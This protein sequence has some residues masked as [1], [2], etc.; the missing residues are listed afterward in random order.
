MAGFEDLV[1]GFEDRG[2]KPQPK[3]VGRLLEAGMGR[4]KDS[5]LELFRGK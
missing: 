3:D 2:R 4:E 1:A 5:P